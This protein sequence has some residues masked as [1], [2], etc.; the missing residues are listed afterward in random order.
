[1]FVPN[2]P[3]EID[4]YR[5]LKTIEQNTALG[6]GYNV[7]MKDLE[8]RGA[9]SLFGYRQSGH[10]SSVGF[11]LYC[12][13][14]KDE[15]NKSKSGSISKQV[16]IKTS[17]SPHFDKNYIK[18]QTQRLDYYYRLSKANSIKE[19]SKIETELIDSFGPINKK[20]LALL[21]IAKLK[22]LFSKTPIEK[23]FIS[24]EKSSFYINNLDV[25]GSL[26]TFFN[27]MSV[28]KQKQLLEYRYENKNTTS[29]VVYLITKNQY[30]RMDVLFSFV[31]FLLSKT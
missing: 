18:T 10:I 22:N 21:N 13:L 29:L 16:E 11:E 6:A 19:I 3:L 7:S 31:N 4:A 8:I 30:P 12:D 15:I 5:R 28:F 1:M 24:K 2:K 26:E 25:F 20:V 27:L 17:F 9:G 23:I 14:L